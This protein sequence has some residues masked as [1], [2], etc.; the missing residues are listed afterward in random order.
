MLQNSRNLE[1]KTCCLWYSRLQS[2]FCFIQSKLNQAIQYTLSY[3]NNRHCRTITMMMEHCGV[4][5]YGEVCLRKLGSILLQK[6]PS[7]NRSDCY[8]HT[9]TAVFFPDYYSVVP[10]VFI[11]NSITFLL[12]PFSFLSST[13][14][15]KTFDSQKCHFMRRKC[16]SSWRN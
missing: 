7:R 15:E 4:Q 13:S 3:R 8:G 16:V 5:S 14:L 12:P 6:F 2:I 10:R 11:H 1:K 9:S